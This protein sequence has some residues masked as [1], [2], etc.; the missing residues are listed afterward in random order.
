MMSSPSLHQCICEQ[1]VRQ[2]GKGN[3][4]MINTQPPSVMKDSSAGPEEISC[5]SSCRGQVPLG[6]T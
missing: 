2:Y 5:K 1:E 6:K 3:L 4:Q